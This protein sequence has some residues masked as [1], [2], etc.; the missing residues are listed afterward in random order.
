MALQRTLSQIE[1]KQGDG[2]YLEGIIV[3][4]T[5][6]IFSAVSFLIGRLR[7]M[8]PPKFRKMPPNHAAKSD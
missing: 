6:R 1:P 3:I 2:T 5:V 7:K 8:P 4:R